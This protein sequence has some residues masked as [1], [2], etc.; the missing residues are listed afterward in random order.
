MS[1]KVTEGTVI[2]FNDFKKKKEA[3]KPRGVLTLWQ[4]SSMKNETDWKKV[5]SHIESNASSNSEVSQVDVYHTD[6]SVDELKKTWKTTKQ[7]KQFLKK[8]KKEESRV[9]HIFVQPTKGA[10]VDGANI[11][12]L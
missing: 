12:T 11:N 7:S 8:I 5:W 10:P 9:T 2:S 6:M 4:V 1:D 3:A